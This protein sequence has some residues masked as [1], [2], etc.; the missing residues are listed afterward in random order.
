ME[1][2]MAAQGAFHKGS[3]PSSADLSEFYLLLSTGLN[4]ISRMV[5]KLQLLSVVGGGGGGG[6]LSH[7][8]FQV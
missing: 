1:K 4:F 8:F 5:A 2:S 3:G 7:L 6:M